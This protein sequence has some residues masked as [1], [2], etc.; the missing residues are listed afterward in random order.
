MGW[1]HGKAPLCR[2]LAYMLSGHRCSCWCAEH[3]H[4]ANHCTHLC[5]CHTAQCCTHVG[6][7][8]L[9]MHSRL[10]CASQGSGLGCCNQFACTPCS[11]AGCCRHGSSCLLVPCGQTPP[12]AA[13]NM[14]CHSCAPQHLGHRPW[15]R[16]GCILCT[17]CCTLGTPAAAP[18]CPFPQVCGD[19]QPLPPR[20]VCLPQ[21]TGHPP[22]AARGGVCAGEDQGRCVTD[23]WG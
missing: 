19:V 5:S 14:F 2:L 4:V 18:C 22:G 23:S 9:G 16:C 15:R 11:T 21:R 12:Q 1:G 17:P 13:T 7:P 8:W 20:Y 6:A 10:K 3:Q